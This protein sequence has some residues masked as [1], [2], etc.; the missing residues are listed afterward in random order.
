MMLGKVA[1]P[2][3][4]P[5]EEGTYRGICVGSYYIGEQE[6]QYNGKTRYVRQVLVTLEFPDATI[7][8]DGEQKPRQLSKHFTASV[9]KKAALRKL[10]TALMGRSYTDDEFRQFDTDDLVGR[11]ALF[12]IT[13]NDSREY[14]NISGWMPLP[15]GMPQP[16]TESELMTFSVEEWDE[17]VFAKLPEWV[18][19]RIKKSMEYRSAHAPESDVDFPETQAETDAGTAAGVD[20]GEE[21]CPF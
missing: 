2:S 5:M 16:T 21:E 13:L 19:D 12:E 7:E 18:Q 6:T 1:K 4:P 11:S 17:E 14:A 3:I 15:K 20:L 9:S 10:A 8:L